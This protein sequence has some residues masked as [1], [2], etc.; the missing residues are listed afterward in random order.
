[1]NLLLHFIRLYL[2]FI[3][4]KNEIWTHLISDINR[5]ALEDFC[6]LYSDLDICSLCPSFL[7]GEAP[8]DWKTSS[9]EGR[10]VAGVT[11]GGCMNNNG[12]WR[13][14]GQITFHVIIKNSKVA[15]GVQFNFY[16]LRETQNDECGW[17]VLCC[18]KRF[19]TQPLNC[20]Q[21]H[22]QVIIDLW[23]HFTVTKLNHF[24]F[25]FPGT[26]VLQENME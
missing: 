2:Y 11:A 16:T 10:W 23:V 20:I 13:R 6:E 9:Y 26:K 24:C 19:Y 25:W 17:P 7:D 3:L 12:T 8:C 21:L 14:S 5:M 15:W 1:M 22:S 4:K 18:F